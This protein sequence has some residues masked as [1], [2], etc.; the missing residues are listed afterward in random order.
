MATS[1]FVPAVYLSKTQSCYITLNPCCLPSLWGT[2]SLETGVSLRS[3]ESGEDEDV[4]EEEERG[5]ERERGA[6]NSRGGRRLFLLKL[7]AD[8]LLL[9]STTGRDK[10]QN[11]AVS[12]L[13]CSPRPFTRPLGVFALTFSVRPLCEWYHSRWYPPP[14]TT[15]PTLSP[16]HYFHSAC[17]PTPPVMRK[18]EPDGRCLGKWLTSDGKI[19][20][21][22]PAMVTSLHWSTS[23]PR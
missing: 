20:M 3:T 23:K 15:T 1:D 2:G 5:R 6:S 18:L 16:N 14:E 17:R 19:V 4:E 22:L 13:V 10:T 11:P 21:P 8:N 7:N 9:I 12:P